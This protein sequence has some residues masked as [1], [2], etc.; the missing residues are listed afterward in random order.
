MLAALALQL[1]RYPPPPSTVGAGYLADAQQRI[2]FGA[3][4]D[5]SWPTAYGVLLAGIAR[6]TASS[7]LDAS[8]WLNGAL[9]VAWSA[10]GWAV[11]RR[12]LGALP[13]ACF[14]GLLASP[15]LL[16]RWAALPLPD[17]PF[18]LLLVPT[19]IWLGRYLL[20]APPTGQWRGSLPVALA[21]LGLQVL[22]PGAGLL[23]WL[24]FGA[25]VIAV[26]AR[27]AVGDGHA[28]TAPR[29][30]LRRGAVI[31]VP[32]LA[33][34]LVGAMLPQ[35]A[36]HRSPVD[37]LAYRVVVAL[38]PVAN[39]AAE[40]RIEDTKRTFRRAEGQPIEAVR[41]GAFGRFD[42]FAAL[43]PADVRDVWLTRLA[44]QPGRFAGVLFDDIRLSHDLLARQLLPFVGRSEA[45]LQPVP[46]YPRADGSTADIVFRTTG[47]VMNQ[48]LPAHAPVAVEVGW[49]LARALAVGGLAGLGAWRLWRVAPLAVT[50]GG[51]FA[52]AY[53]PVA[54]A[55]TSLSAGAVLPLVPILLLLQ[56]VGFAW[57]VRA[58]AGEDRRRRGGAASDGS[59]RA[60][61][62]P[63]RAA[64]PIEAVVVALLTAL[65]LAQLLAYPAT[66][67]PDPD[68]YVSYARGLLD[69]GRLP[70]SGRLP[71]YPLVLALLLQTAGDPLAEA[72]Y[73]AQ[74][75][76][77]VAFALGLW[78]FTRVRFGR[79]PALGLL[80]ILAAPSYVA[81]MAVIMLP[82]V[83][84][85]ILMAP[86]LVAVGWWALADRPVGGWR[87][88]PILAAA[89]FALQTIRATTFALLG[90]FAVTLVVGW[91]IGQRFGGGDRLAACRVVL[92]RAGAV[93][94]VALVVALVS[95]RFLDTGA[96]R[97]NAEILAYR[98]I[99]RLP[100]ATDSEAERRVEAARRRF[101]I[102]E[103]EEIEDA[104]FGTY[105]NLNLMAAVH[106]ADAEAVWRDRLAA[107]PLRYLASIVDEVRLGHHLLARVALPYFYDVERYSLFLARYPRNDGSPEG[108]LFRA[109][110]LIVADGRPPAGRFPFEVAT[111]TVV[112][113]LGLIWG[114]LWLGIAGAWSRYGALAS[115][116]VLLLGAFVVAVATTNTV[117]PRY[118]LPFAP[119]VHLG[120]ALGAAAIARALIRQSR[121]R[122]AAV[123]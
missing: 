1:L 82:D 34:Q 24:A 19:A 64:R 13:A 39:S 52:I 33:S 62:A 61:G 105:A 23:L 36:L 98:V 31:A 91:A 2:G 55:V 97:Q 120:Q 42:L 100:A 49:A 69:T 80:G 110:G 46:P 32:L 88:L 101:P 10:G 54:A 28:L 14:L 7:P 112:L 72:V 16:A 86:Y 26:A 27:R 92:A 57:I 93:L 67:D 18:A 50:A 41:F 68:G 25:V 30:V 71:G 85:S 83:P 40:R 96:R 116:L 15:N 6:A 9:L 66:G 115:S 56:A 76:A 79:L 123:S 47:I 20:A 89:A 122:R 45:L 119:L 4:P 103:G 65:L 121:S 118:L 35:P 60:F 58:V 99:S 3:A 111:A 95:D 74:L 87:W 22:H 81:R 106:P 8:F 53:L 12:R 48:D 77:Y 63:S 59:D 90:L 114:L 17:A 29:A 21:L 11:V 94:A 70:P 44:A 78:A 75:T 38:P 107:H 37:Q 104:R 113:E 108:R 73:R 51:L 5:G 109:T 43:R 117:D 102:E 84:Y